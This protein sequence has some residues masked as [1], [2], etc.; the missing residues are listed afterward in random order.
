MD[1][2]TA[3]YLLVLVSAV[4]ATIALW[5]LVLRS[6]WRDAGVWD[7]TRWAGRTGGLWARLRHRTG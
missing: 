4:A 1:G 2:F 6:V 5:V 7:R 3:I